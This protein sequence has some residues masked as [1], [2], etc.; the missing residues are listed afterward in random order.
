M[1]ESSR[2]LQSASLK[3]AARLFEWSEGSQL[4]QETGASGEIAESPSVRRAE[5]PSSG[6]LPLASL[7]VVRQAEGLRLSFVQSSL[8]SPSTKQSSAWR[9]TAPEDGESSSTEVS[10][11]HA[12]RDWRVLAQERTNGSADSS[13]RV[14]LADD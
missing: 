13:E 3:K 1:T 7:P 5:L 10:L 14:R 6:L 9:A 11:Q 4:E 8:A 2:C 12:V